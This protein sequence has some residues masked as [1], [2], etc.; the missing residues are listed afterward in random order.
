MSKLV[1]KNTNCEALPDFKDFNKLYDEL[2]RSKYVTYNDYKKLRKLHD[3]AAQ[4]IQNYIEKLNNYYADLV[5]NKAKS[6]NNNFKI[7][8]GKRKKIFDEKDIENI[9]YL[10]S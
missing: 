9:N 3:E 4:N 5:K 8:N 6:A 1:W 10:K 2:P 7:M